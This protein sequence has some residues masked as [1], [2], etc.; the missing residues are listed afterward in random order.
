VH[1]VSD[2][3]TPRFPTFL[4]VR[5]DLT[6]QDV[7]DQAK[8][9]KP[10]S[11]LQ[12]KHSL[13]NKQHSVLFSAIPSRDPVTGNKVVTSDDE[14]ESAQDAASSSAASSAAPAA[15]GGKTP[16]KYGAACYQTSEQHLQAFS[17]P[18]AAPKAAPASADKKPCTFGNA[19]YR[20]SASHLA[21]FSHPDKTGDPKKDIDP[22][23]MMKE[24]S[25]DEDDD[26]TEE[27]AALGPGG[28]GGA[29]AAAEAPDQ[30]AAAAAPRVD[31]AGDALEAWL[32]SEDVGLQPDIAHTVAEELRAEEIF[33]PTEVAQLTEK[34]LEKIGVKLGSRKK[35]LAA[36][37]PAPAAAEDRPPCMYGAKCTRMNEAHRAKFSHGAAP[38]KRSAEGPA[39]ADDPDAQ[40]PDAKQRKVEE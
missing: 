8:V 29:A 35:I 36:A 13:I 31:Q 19:C 15:A 16:C 1:K 39:G 3:G 26:G 25:D 12:K 40:E 28:G 33:T 7:L 24:A 20:R 18:Q 17:H 5:E 30:A 34:E 27:D 22:S 9:D 14:D 37:A 32:A 11:Q 4:R 38:V 2:S 6:W 23:I 21:A 10:F